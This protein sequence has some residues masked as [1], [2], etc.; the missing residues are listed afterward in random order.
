MINFSKS[1]GRPS[2][3]YII[4]LDMAKELAMVENNERGRQARQY[5]IEVEKRYRHTGSLEENHPR[6][7][8]A[9]YP[10]K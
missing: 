4:S 9:D 6:R 7:S 8:Y 10:R 5:F 1:L 3:E 2:K